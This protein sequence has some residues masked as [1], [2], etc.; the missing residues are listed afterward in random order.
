MNMKL[1]VNRAVVYVINDKGPN[2]R[3]TLCNITARVFVT[4]LLA[5]HFYNKIT[6]FILCTS[7]PTYFGL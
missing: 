6:N 7:S 5:K 3:F 1:S 2:V 4:K